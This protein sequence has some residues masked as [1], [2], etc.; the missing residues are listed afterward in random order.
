MTE[1]VGG[2]RKYD[3]AGFCI[4]CGDSQSKL[5][6]E[7]ILPLGIAGNALVFPAASCST[8]AAV[9]GKVENELL[10]QGLG[11]FR[12]RIN[13]PTRR[14]K[15]RPAEPLVGIGRRLGDGPLQDSGERMAIPIM[16]VP[17]A[18]FC[19]KFLRLPGILSGLLP[20]GEIT[21]E[22]WCRAWEAEAALQRVRPTQEGL[23]LGGLRPI[24]FAR[25]LAKV[26]HGY[27]VAEIGLESFEPLLLDLILGRSEE[28]SH[29]IGGDGR[30][31]PPMDEEF[32]LTSGWHE[33]VHGSFLV[34][35]MR[36]YANLGAP[37]YSVVVGR[38]RETPEITK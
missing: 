10:K 8:C 32:Y 12:H 36:L 18:Y 7:H 23:H 21:W 16:E 24:T 30:D 1:R 4:Y 28:I 38:K 31:M 29:L 34:V 33:D 35:V 2:G 15:D 19:L 13:S 25:F 20:S 3:P 37:W 6:E 11:L 5:G 9:T 27:A 26:A 14:R 22:F 17:V